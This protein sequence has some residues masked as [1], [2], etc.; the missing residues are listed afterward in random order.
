MVTL[1]L[2]W[3][4]NSNNFHYIEKWLK[5]NQ[6]IWLKLFHPHLK[7]VHMASIL[8]ELVSEPWM[9]MGQKKN[10]TS[11]P[12]KVLGVVQEI[13]RMDETPFE[14][15]QCHYTWRVSCG[16]SSQLLQ[17][18]SYKILHRNSAIFVGSESVFACHKNVFSLGGI[19]RDHNR[20]HS[21]DCC[22]KS[23][24]LGRPLFCSS[25]T[26]YKQYVII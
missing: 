13:Y 22:T 10:Y 16:T 26:D 21:L 25:I 17:K 18:W 12:I 1:T 14:R 7:R 9:Y 19:L 20:S 4:E 23:L 24:V 11:T 6:A 3:S 8:I 2:F 15:G 5:L